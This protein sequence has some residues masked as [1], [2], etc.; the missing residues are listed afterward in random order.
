M[1]TAAKKITAIVSKWSLREKKFAMATILRD[2]KS[3][4]PLTIKDELN[5]TVGIVMPVRSR[6]LP[7]DMS[8]STPYVEEIKRRLATVDQSIPI[9]EVNA[10]LERQAAQRDPK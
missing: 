4:E 10:R 5:E 3:T 9:E 2:L 6:A 7:F 1:P 8:K